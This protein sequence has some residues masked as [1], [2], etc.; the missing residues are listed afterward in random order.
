VTAG[1]VGGLDRLWRTVQQRGRE[2]PDGSYV[3]RLL[4]AGTDRIAR[5]I[6]EE[7]AE[8]IVAAKNRSPDQLAGEMADLWF[9]SLLLLEDAGLAPAD[10][11][12]VLAARER[13]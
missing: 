8:V 1:E 12:R 13:A 2:R 11:Y 6:G 7:S 9:H 10:V 3:V 5:K 4:D